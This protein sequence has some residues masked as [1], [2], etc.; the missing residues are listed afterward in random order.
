MKLRKFW[1]TR[2]EHQEMALG[3]VVLGVGW[4][5]EN[6]W[7][8]LLE[9]AEDKEALSPTYAG[10]LK[11]AYENTKTLEESGVR[12]Q[13]ISIDVDDLINWCKENKVPLNGQSR[14]SYIA[15]KQKRKTAARDW[16][17]RLDCRMSEGA[18]AALTSPS[19]SGCRSSTLSSFTRAKGGLVFPF[20]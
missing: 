4:Y 8:L 12:Y 17:T 6:Q 1:R 5:Q 7:A 19:K 14:S 3:G 16:P 13:K 18:Y 9:H 10:W 20:S 15:K 11:N 2:K